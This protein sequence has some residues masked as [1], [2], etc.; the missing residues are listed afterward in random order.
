MRR[1]LL[2][3]LLL[4][5][6]VPS[7]CLSCGPASQ[8]SLLVEDTIGWGCPCP[9]YVLASAK[10]EVTSDDQFIYPVFLPGVR[11]LSWPPADGR[12]RLTGRYTGESVDRYEWA[13]RRGEASPGRG[14]GREY[15]E[16]RH[17]V[18]E[19]SGWCVV[20]WET[21]DDDAEAP[22]FDRTEICR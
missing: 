21:P 3:V 19:V 11:E 10:G 12:Y 15:Y 13:R 16:T 8:G 7:I 2:R 14:D 18:F 20:S 6:L 22:Q 17:P 1:R 4:A 9:P 5:S